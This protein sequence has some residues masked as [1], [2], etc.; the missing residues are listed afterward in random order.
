MAKNAATL[1]L[2]VARLET[3]GPVKQEIQKSA[4][5]FGLENSNIIYSQTR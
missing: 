4:Q 5:D 1:V 3:K 2:V